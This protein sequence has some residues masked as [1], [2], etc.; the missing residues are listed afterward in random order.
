MIAPRLLSVI[1]P[2][3]AAD[4]LVIKGYYRICGT[5][6]SPGNTDSSIVLR[7]IIVASATRYLVVDPRTLRTKLVDSAACAMI[8]D[9]LDVLRRRFAATPYCKALAA[10]EANDTSLLDA[11]ITR[12]RPTLRGVNLTIDLCPSKRPLD[13]D[14]FSRLFAAFGPQ[15]RPV[16]VAISITGAWMREHPDD[17][18]WLIASVKKG[19]LEVAW[20]NHSNHHHAGKD[21]PLRKNFLLEDGTDMNDEVLKTES[22]LVSHGLTP[23]V[24]FRFPGLVSDA[25]VFRAV[26]AF[27]LIP[28]GSDAWLAKGQQPNTG[29]IVLIHANGNDPLGVEKFIQ[30][31]NRKQPAISNKT[32]LLY[33]LREGIVATESDSSEQ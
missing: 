12:L 20:I 25:A 2:C 31:V 17:L 21:V 32:W 11:G 33:D 24:F 7:K 15:E 22:T 8:P 18:D 16:P 19:D 27:G 26:T 28:I 6:V 13:R 4:K 23:S 5:V 9:S 1:A 30:L 29:S 3:R 10:A 14:L